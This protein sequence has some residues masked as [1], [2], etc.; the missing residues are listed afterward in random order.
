MEKGDYVMSEI[1]IT[2]G[3]GKMEGINSINTNSLTNPFCIRMSSKDNLVCSKC[4]SNRLLKCRSINKGGFNESDCR[5]VLDALL[6]KG[7]I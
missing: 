5:K 6:S 4:Y 7:L 2:T 3:K 1:W